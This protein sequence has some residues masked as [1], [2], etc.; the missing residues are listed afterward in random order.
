VQTEGLAEISVSETV[1]IMRVLLADW[2][3]E[4]VGVPES[5]DIRGCC[6]FAEHLHDGVAGNKVDQEKND[7]D[8]DPEDRKSKEDTAERLPESDRSAH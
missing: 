1:P 8:D 7:G 6:A 2:R 3:I 4:A 5:R